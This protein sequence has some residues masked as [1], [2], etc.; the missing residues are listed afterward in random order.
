MLIDDELLPAVGQPATVNIMD[1]ISDGNGFEILWFFL[2][3][4]R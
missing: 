4:V 2:F 1:A 3:V